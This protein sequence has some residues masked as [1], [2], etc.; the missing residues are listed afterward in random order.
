MN[1]EAKANEAAKKAD[2]LRL[3]LKEEVAASPAKTKADKEAREAANWPWNWLSVE[4]QRKG[5]E[6]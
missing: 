5:K 2:E 1:M 6:T 3:K 4:I